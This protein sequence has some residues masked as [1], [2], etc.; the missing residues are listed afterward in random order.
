MQAASQRSPCWADLQPELLLHVAGLLGN[1]DRWGEPWQAAW[2][3]GSAAEGGWGGGPRAA[4]TVAARRCIS[5]EL[6]PTMG[7]ASPQHLTRP[8]CRPPAG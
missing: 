8:H 5:H 2:Y 4:V 1:E 3:H 7:A 6:R